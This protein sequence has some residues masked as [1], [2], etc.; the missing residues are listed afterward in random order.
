M[1]NQFAPYEQKPP[2]IYQEPP[3]ASGSGCGL[4][5]LL[6]CLG[7]FVLCVILCAGGVW[8]VQQNAGKWMTAMI[9]EVIVAGVNNSDIPAGEKTEV[10]A[11]IDR[12]VDAFKTGKI[13]GEDLEP[14]LKKLEK[15]PVFVMMQSWGIE[16]A[17]LDPSGLSDEEKQQGR[18]TINRAFR[19]LV[20]GKI[21]Q[22]QFTGVVPQ[23]P[24]SVD[25]KIENGKKVVTTHSG[26]RSRL[27]D[28]EV[29]KL[30]ADLKKLADDAEI[31]DEPFTVDI[32]D[33]VKKLVDELLSPQA[34]PASAPAGKAEAEQAPAKA[35][36]AEQP[37][38]K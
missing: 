3:R 25:V 26:E 20:E 5:I 10:I 7:V 33:E 1:S 28:E 8:Y 6:G 2:P 15:S 23:Q 29:R 24:G 22:E 31:P 13:K 36:P 9:R 32:G 17:Y 19:G 27:S 18:R 37:P 21:T 30:L 11:Q 4:G 16:K 12:V 35:P 14:V 34:Q 38:A